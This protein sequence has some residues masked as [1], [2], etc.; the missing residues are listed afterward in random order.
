[1]NWLGTNAGWRKHK[2]WEWEWEW[3]WKEEVYR[4][5]EVKYGNLFEIKFASLFKLIKQTFVK[6]AV[7]IKMKTLIPTFSYLMW[8]STWK[9]VYIS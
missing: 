8:F 3:E 1:M 9:Y 5:N 7:V 6:K 4:V 2:P